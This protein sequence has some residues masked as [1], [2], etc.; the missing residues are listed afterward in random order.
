MAGG[1]FL[2]WWRVTARVRE[3]EGGL[4]D[5]PGM[6]LSPW[7]QQ[8]LQKI[9]MSETKIATFTCAGLYSIVHALTMRLFARGRK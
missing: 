3:S 9:T 4:V 6:H 2:M 1:S 7:S 8:K 5:T